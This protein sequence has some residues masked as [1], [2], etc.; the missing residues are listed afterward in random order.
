MTDKKK[1]ILFRIGTVAVL[2]IIAAV[3]IVIGRGHTVYFDN[4]VIEYNGQTYTCPYKVVILKGDEQQAKLYERERGM[5]TNIGQTM[6]LTFEITEEKGGNE[7]TSKHTFK[8]PY[9]MDGI[10]IN[11][12]AYLAGLPEE[13]YLSEFVSLATEVS[14]ETED[15]IVTDEFGLGGDY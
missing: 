15:G 11:L 12:P 6:T 7:V 4:K 2:L 9:S 5:V 13:A 3:M 1:M 10:V 14:L 8:L